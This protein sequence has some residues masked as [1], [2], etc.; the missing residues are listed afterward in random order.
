MTIN[1]AENP[2]T[3]EEGGSDVEIGTSENGILTV[4][5]TKPLNAQN[6]YPSDDELVHGFTITNNSN[7]TVVYNV[8]LINVT[9][10][11]TSNNFVYRI[12]K[13]NQTLVNETV[14]PKTDTNLLS[15]LVIYPGE[16][17]TFS[18]NYKL[19]DIGSEQNYDQGK[20]Y[21]GTVEIE[22]VSAR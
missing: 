2:S 10:T 17:A 21:S 9:N 20:N 14:A 7:R 16:T 15:D 13:D 22:I 3:S 1:K 19:I 5:F 12:V 11:F 8:N 18:I 4:N 6:I